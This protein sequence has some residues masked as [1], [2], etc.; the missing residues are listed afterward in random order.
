[1]KLKLSSFSILS[2][3][4]ILLVFCSYF[5]CFINFLVLFKKLIFVIVLLSGEDS[6][7]FWQ[8]KD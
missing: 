1:M 6:N 2:P 8:Q 7:P 5:G 4:S 3:F